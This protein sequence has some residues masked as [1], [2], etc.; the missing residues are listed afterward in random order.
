MCTK[1]N[2]PAWVNLTKI[3]SLMLIFVGYSW[4][5]PQL[6]KAAPK[7]DLFYFTNPSPLVTI[8][9][10]SISPTLIAHPSLK[11]SS[12]LWQFGN[13]FETTTE[14]PIYT[15][16]YAKAG[17]YTLIVSARDSHGEEHIATLVI[18]VAEAAPKAQVAGLFIS[19]TYRPATVN[20]NGLINFIKLH[21]AFFI[22]ILI[23]LLS[24]I[25]PGFYYREA[26]IHQATIDPSLLVATE[27]VRPLIGRR[28]GSLTES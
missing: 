19:E 5:S 26:K 7:D 8:A 10:E 17:N 2:L 24:L 12:F 28:V 13:K 1:T 27:A 18:Q 11:I 14:L 20:F 25:L 4:L 23:I 16:S 6:A 22:A 21:P 9:K 15:F 3:F